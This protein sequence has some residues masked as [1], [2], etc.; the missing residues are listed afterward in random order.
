[1]ASDQKNQISDNILMWA[2]PWHML[3]TGTVLKTMFSL[4]VQ[5]CE[6]VSV[7]DMKMYHLYTK[8]CLYKAVSS[9]KS[10]T[11]WG[12]QPSDAREIPSITWY[13]KICPPPNVLIVIVL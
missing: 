1:M 7:C 9:S 4:Y 13:E 2:S 10:E 3:H 8:L 5:Q 11:K 6:C 12:K